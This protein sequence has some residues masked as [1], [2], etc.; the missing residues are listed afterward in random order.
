MMTEK[1]IWPEPCVCVCP[2]VFWLWPNTP[3]RIVR[4]DLTGDPNRGSD[5]SHVQT[6]HLRTVEAEKDHTCPTPWLHQYVQNEC[7]E[8]SL[9][10]NYQTVY[11]GQTFS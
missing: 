5:L 10:A 2:N 8:Q 7:L 6:E 11:W 9:G 4:I 1:D 3:V